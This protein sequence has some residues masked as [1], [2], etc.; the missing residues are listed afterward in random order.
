MRFERNSDIT[1]NVKLIE[2]MKKEI[3]MSIGDLYDLIFK[4]AKPLDEA[5]QD[6]L[7]NII[8]M[9]YLLGKRLGVNF[10]DIDY[11]IDKKIKQG[12]KEDHSVESWYGDLSNLKTHLDKRE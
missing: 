11:Q 2:W 12:I 5:L 10:R 9:T 1:K 3:I 7:A 8:M 6:T 4:G